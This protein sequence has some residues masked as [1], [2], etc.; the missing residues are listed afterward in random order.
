MTMTETH[1]ELRA[2]VASL[3]L[4][5]SA[6]FI[7][8]SASRNRDEKA[9]TLNWSVTIEGK[10]SSLTV[11]YAQGIGHVPGW[12]ELPRTLY[13]EDLRKEF[14]NA[15]EKGVYPIKRLHEHEHKH[16]HGT[17]L[18]ILP[19]NLTKPLPAPDVLDVLYSLVL[20]SSAADETFEDWCANYGYDTDSRKAEATYRACVDYGIRLRRILGADVLARLSELF[21]D[22]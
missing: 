17:R 13:F 4:R 2:Y 9:K 18:D 6:R 15:S 10:G 7:P 21:Q 19:G 5:Y 3:G 20:D 22:Y 12:R 16:E 1:A 14:D 8:Q 11:D